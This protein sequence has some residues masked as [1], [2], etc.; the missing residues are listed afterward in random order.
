MCP[1]H[2]QCLEAVESLEQAQQ[3]TMWD[4]H[5]TRAL[6]GHVPSTAFTQITE[7][8]NLRKMISGHST[9]SW[10][11]IPRIWRISRR[12]RKAWIRVRTQGWGTVQYQDV[13]CLSKVQ[14]FGHYREPNSKI[15][16]IVRDPYYGHSLP[17]SLLMVGGQADLR[18]TSDN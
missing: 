16:K 2:S 17:T 4:L 8:V 14:L 5:R 18:I 11:W 12:L 15:D 9:T 1:G 13:L 7:L 6:C 3:A 10:R